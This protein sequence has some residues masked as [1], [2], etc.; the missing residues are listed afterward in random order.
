MSVWSP[1]TT[2]PSQGCPG[3][4]L[5]AKL[6]VRSC[7]TLEGGVVAPVP[8]PS[9]NV[10]GFFTL[11]RFPGCSDMS[12]GVDG[13]SE[14]SWSFMQTSQQV[15]KTKTRVASEKRAEPEPWWRSWPTSVCFRGERTPTAAQL[16]VSLVNRQRCAALTHWKSALPASSCWGSALV[17]WA[18]SSQVSSWALRRVSLLQ[19]RPGVRCWSP[20]PPE[21]ATQAWWACSP[22][23]GPQ[24]SFGTCSQV[25]LDPEQGLIRWPTEINAAATLLRWHKDPS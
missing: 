23:L 4:P 20:P 1:K 14:G 15:R 9:F 11:K 16:C 13:T 8:L 2:E 18:G 12:L 7:S 19:T 25:T 10:V 22:L 21:T 17:R 6:P 3:N 5:K 24:R